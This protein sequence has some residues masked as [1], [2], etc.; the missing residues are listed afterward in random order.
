MGVDGSADLRPI[1]EERGADGRR[2]STAA[3]SGYNLPMEDNLPGKF[4]GTISQC[5]EDERQPLLNSNWTVQ[6]DY[7]G[8]PRTSFESDGARKRRAVIES[9]ATS[10]E[11][12]EVTAIPVPFYVTLWLWCLHCLNFAFAKIFWRGK[13]F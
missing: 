4:N 8:F 2:Y 9:S 7:T 10:S 5:V 3:Q 13:E 12:S 6:G 1:R 11:T